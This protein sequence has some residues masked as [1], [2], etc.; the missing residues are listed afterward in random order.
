[1]LTLPGLLIQRSHPPTSPPFSIHTTDEP[2]LWGWRPFLGLSNCSRARSSEEYSILT[3]GEGIR[4]SG[5]W[6]N[7]SCQS[8]PSM[9]S[10]KMLAGG[11]LPGIQ[12]RKPNQVTCYQKTS[13]FFLLF[14]FCFLLFQCLSIQEQPKKGKRAQNS[15][16]ERRWTPDA[17]QWSL[18]LN[19]GQPIILCYL[20][21]S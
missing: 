4:P 2:F 18:L 20:Q 10:E 3:K 8:H 6:K 9:T 19:Q 7:R 12:P 21:S 14:V 1:M 17:L 16:E 11:S 13:Q 15:Y 5:K